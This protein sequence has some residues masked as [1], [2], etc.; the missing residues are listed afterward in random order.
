LGGVSVELIYQKDKNEKN[1]NK[2]YRLPR[3]YTQKKKSRTKNINNFGLFK[4]LCLFM[5]KEKDK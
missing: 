2:K 3:V 4:K 5:L 1:K